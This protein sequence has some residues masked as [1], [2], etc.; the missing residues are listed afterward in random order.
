MLWCAGSGLCGAVN[1][2]PWL[3]GSSEITFTKF[4]VRLAPAPVPVPVGLDTVRCV[5]VQMDARRLLWIYILLCATAAVVTA[6]PCTNDPSWS[7]TDPSGDTVNCAFIA[8][9][10]ADGMAPNCDPAITGLLGTNAHLTACPLAC[11]LCVAYPPP[12]PPLVPPGTCVDDPNW[13]VSM[14]N[15][16]TGTVE[17]VTCAVLAAQTAGHASCDPMGNFAALFGSHPRL[18]QRPATHSIQCSMPTDTARHCSLLRFKQLP[19]PLP[20][21][22]QH[23]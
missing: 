20:R 16:G 15:G 23:V 10:L 19:E 6:T 21:H 4:S 7:T 3:F 18:T 17:S 9:A 12:P 5:A 8:N 22:M 11:G 1:T 14:T 13:S 2:W